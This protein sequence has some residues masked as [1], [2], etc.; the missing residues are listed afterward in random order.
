[1]FHECIIFYNRA[2]SD[3]LYC[4][5]YVYYYVSFTVVNEFIVLNY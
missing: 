1:M 4:L 5:L 2:K 3:I